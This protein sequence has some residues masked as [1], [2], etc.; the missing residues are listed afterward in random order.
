AETHA[1]LGRWAAAAPL[2]G[3]ALPIVAAK[4]GLENEVM[5]GILT[6]IGAAAVAAGRPAQGVAPLERAVAL[7]E[8]AKIAPSDLAATRFALAR[9]L[10]APDLAAEARAANPEATAELEALLR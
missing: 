9:A 2:Y 7:G 4:L 1:R 10:R 5:V 8:K 3:R 6:G